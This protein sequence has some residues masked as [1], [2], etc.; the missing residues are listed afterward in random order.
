M[1]SYNVDVLLDTYY[2]DMS[3]AI[4]QKNSSAYAESLKLGTDIFKGESA[5]SDK[6]INSFNA[7]TKQGLLSRINKQ[8]REVN[9]DEHQAKVVARHLECIWNLCRKARASGN[10]ETGS[11][12]EA[13]E[14][15]IKKFNAFLELYKTQGGWL[16][17]A[18]EVLIMQTRTLAQLADREEKRETNGFLIDTK[19]I[20]D[21]CF[22]LTIMVS[23][24]TFCLVSSFSC[25][26]ELHLRMD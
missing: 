22:R 23:T 7:V 14:C 1:V 16:V 8:E 11:Y 12:W 19:R 9:F 26:A 20:V 10:L 3:R 17:E 25:R 6:V 13:M 24:H 21:S 5:N 4:D 18:L 2:Q 15:Q